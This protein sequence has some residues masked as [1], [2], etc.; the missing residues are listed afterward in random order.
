MPPIKESYFMFTTV[1]GVYIT[2]FYIFQQVTIQLNPAI[3]LKIKTENKL[4]KEWKF[5]IV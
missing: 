3:S 4:Q 1:V 2:E 5:L